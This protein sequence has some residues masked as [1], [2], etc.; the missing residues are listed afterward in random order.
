MQARRAASH[1][2]GTVHACAA[3]DD[4]VRWLKPRAR[5]RPTRAPRRSR[6]SLLRLTASLGVGALLTVSTAQSAVAPAASHFT[7]DVVGARSLVQR[8]T[9]LPD[10]AQAPAFLFETAA[11]G[12]PRFSEQVFDAPDPSPFE[13]APFA[14]PE[15]AVGSGDQGPRLDPDELLE[16]GR[17]RIRRG[18]VETIL[19]A[20]KATGVAPAYMMALADKESSFLHD[21]KAPTSSAEGLFQF[22]DRTWLEVV[23][24]FGPKYG[25]EFAAAAVD[26]VNGQPVVA[27][28]AI[29]EWV[30]GLRRNPYLAALMAGEMLQRDKAR[31]E[32]RIGR[33]LKPSEYYLA[34]FLGPDSARKL[35]ELVS[36]RPKQSAPRVFPAA[37]RA[38]RTLF[39]A[40]EKRKTRHLTVTEVYGKLDRMIDARLGRY[41]GVTAFAPVV[42][43]SAIQ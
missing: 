1:D 42:Q 17:V 4:E 19:R 8:T 38:N 36:D 43:A 23:R 41:D 24:D 14:L 27:S 25:M 37:A 28:P 13:V 7:P 26:T 11:F 18:L 32:Q 10:V 2:A 9:A 6:P 5:L 21:A 20:A 39:F 40:R 35:L 16:F 31:I 22:I 29:R 3:N 33:E 30:L 34:H 12:E 15:A